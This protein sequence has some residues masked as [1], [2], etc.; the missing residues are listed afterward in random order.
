MITGN[1]MEESADTILGRIIEAADYVVHLPNDIK[2]SHQLI[3]SHHPHMIIYPEIGMDPFAYFLALSRL[4]PI[5]S[6]IKKL[7]KGVNCI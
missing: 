3:M 6:V 1:S 5:Q 7:V 2:A 4:A